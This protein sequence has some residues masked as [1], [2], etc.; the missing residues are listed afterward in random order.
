M[1]KTAGAPHG[2]GAERLARLAARSARVHARTSPILRG[3][4]EEGV[5]A[6]SS[7]RERN[8]PNKGNS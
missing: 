4:V 2:A 8:A 5:E 7:L 1:R 3:L 6:R